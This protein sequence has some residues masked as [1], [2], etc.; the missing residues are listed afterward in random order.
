MP[1]KSVDS[2]SLNNS[3]GVTLEGGITQKTVEIGTSNDSYTEITNGLNENDQVISSTLTA[4]ASAKTSTSSSS[5]RSSNSTNS[6]ESKNI[7]M[8]G[9]GGPPN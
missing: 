4:A 9:L 3:K 7:M 2:S 5:S 6:G 8:P 1:K